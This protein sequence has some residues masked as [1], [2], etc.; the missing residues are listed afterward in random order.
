M[1]EQE[2]NDFNNKVQNGSVWETN[3]YFVNFQEYLTKCFWNN[4]SFKCSNAFLNHISDVGECFTFNPGLQT[5]HRTID[6]RIGM[7][8]KTCFG[9]LCITLNFTSHLFSKVLHVVVWKVNTGV[10]DIAVAVQRGNNAWLVNFALTRFYSKRIGIA[11]EVLYTS[12]FDWLSFL[13]S[14]ARVMMICCLIRSKFAQ[15]RALW[16]PIFLLTTFLGNGLNISYYDE[17]HYKNDG[18]KNS[19]R[20]FINTNQSEYCGHGLPKRGAGYFFNIHEIN[21]YPSFL[22]NPSTLISPGYDINVVMTPIVYDRQTEN[23]GK[24][25]DFVNVYLTSNPEV[26]V[27]EQ[28]Y[29]QCTSEMIIRS[30]NCYPSI[31]GGFR[32]IILLRS[33]SFDINR[34]D[35]DV[36]LGASFTC[37]KKWIYDVLQ[38]TSINSLCPYCKQPCH[39]TK[40][41]FDLT[42]L[43]ISK[44]NL[45]LNYFH[46]LTLEEYLKNYIF[47]KFSM[48]SNM[49][50]HVEERQKFTLRDLFI[51]I[52]GNIGL[53]LGM[54]FLS[55]FE[56]IHFILEL[57]ECFCKHW[58][59]NRNLRTE[60][61][62][63]KIRRNKIKTV[64]VKSHNQNLGQISRL[65]RRQSINYGVEK[66]PKG[67]NTEG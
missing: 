25:T 37:M 23:L 45:K 52:G 65:K 40:Y 6:N 60:N 57:L 62:N 38:N 15:V 32:K 14:Y 66:I 35:V 10:T 44:T 20:L 56:I 61:R 39:E 58:K 3:E 42:Y 51:F 4:K 22:L 33:L 21:R 41:E 8:L 67:A 13:K 12:H 36:C 7:P 17:S 53:Y 54:S 27:L 34:N 29:M 55:L 16:A 46:N 31:L 28:C 48:K 11:D 64:Q 26:Y 49:I 24:C 5:A 43:R 19:L 47:V 9:K 1:K 30:C 50:Q 63:K 2:L 59:R 18:R